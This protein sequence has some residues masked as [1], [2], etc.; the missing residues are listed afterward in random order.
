MQHIQECKSE[1]AEKLEITISK[2][3][4]S[5][6]W[7]RSLLSPKEIS[8]HPRTVMLSMASLGN[9]CQKILDL[10]PRKWIRCQTCVS[11]LY[12]RSCILQPVEAWTG[13]K[14]DTNDHWKKNLLI[15]MIRFNLRKKESNRLAVE[16]TRC[17]VIDT[18]SAIVGSVL[19]QSVSEQF[20]ECCHCS[21]DLI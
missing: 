5:G 10:Y 3:E 21:N 4:P 13:E 15:N 9:N 16:L 7:V 1:I 20:A 8:T 19:E 6:L 2:K 12:R 17:Y 11:H 14:T 18:L